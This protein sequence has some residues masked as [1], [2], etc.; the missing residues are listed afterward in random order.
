VTKPRI[1]ALDGLRGIAVLMVVLGHY[2]GTRLLHGWGKTLIGPLVSGADGVRIFFVLSGFIITRILLDE[3][4]RTG[5]VAL[6]A[7]YLR[8]LTKLLPPLVVYVAVLYGLSFFDATG[9]GKRDILSALFFL[10]ELKL[11]AGCYLLNHT[12]TLSVEEIFYLTWAPL[13]RYARLNVL[14]AVLGALVVG[15]VVHRAVFPFISLTGIAAFWQWPPLRIPFFGVADGIAI[16]ALAALFYRPFAPKRWLTAA[17]IALAFAFYLLHY[18]ELFYT[19]HVLQSLCVAL[20]IAIVVNG[21]GGPVFTLLCSRPLLAV[22]RI[23]YSL[24][25]FQMLFLVNE[26]EVPHLFW[27]QNNLIGFVLAF[28][29][30][31]ASF[32]LLETKLTAHMRRRLLLQVAPAE[33]PTDGKLL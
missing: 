30:G 4:L 20:V 33:L 23:S 31:A 1:A 27:F 28:A 17:A 16:G 15:A 11:S 22:G 5:S 24:Y 12:W 14:P 8:R 6:R 13:A 7:F 29:S 26:N 10:Y 18:V 3:R 19:S 25:V 21:G 9:C 32:Y 2:P